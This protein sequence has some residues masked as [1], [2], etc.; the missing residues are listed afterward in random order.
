[1]T[2]FTVRINF[3]ISDFLITWLESQTGFVRRVERSDFHYT[4]EFNLTGPE[5][6]ALKTAFHDRLI[7]V[8]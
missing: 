8:L 3:P 7:E 4:V 1:M 5:A 2:L 6:Q